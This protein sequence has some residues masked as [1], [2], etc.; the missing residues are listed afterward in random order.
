MEANYYL[1]KINATLLY[2]IYNLHSD[3]LYT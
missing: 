3:Y 2:E 1:K